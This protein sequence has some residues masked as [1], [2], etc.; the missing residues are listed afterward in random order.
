MNAEVLFSSEYSV[1]TG[2]AARGLGPCLDMEIAEKLV[3]KL[4]LLIS[5]YGKSELPP[6]ITFTSGCAP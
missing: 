3:L 6:Y 4:A 5:C 2:K 1:S